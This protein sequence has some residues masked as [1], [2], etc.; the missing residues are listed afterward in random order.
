M[1]KIVPNA[2]KFEV[3]KLSLLWSF[4]IV[5]FMKLS[6][7]HF[8]E[9]TKLSLMYL[10]TWLSLFCSCQ[11]VIFMKQSH[12]ITK[13]SLFCNHK[14]VI[15]KL[16]LFCSYQFFIA[17]LS[18]ICTYQIV[19]LPRWHYQIVLTKNL[20]VVFKYYNIFLFL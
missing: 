9:V 11:I 10:Y 16:S 19:T 4:L 13:L 14:I 1:I 7:C 17:N 12:F 6:N 15:Y 3:T 2:L 18:L 20:S 5:T 8:Y